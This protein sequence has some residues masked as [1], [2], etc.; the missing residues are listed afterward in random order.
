MT[1]QSIITKTKVKTFDIEFDASLADLIVYHEQFI[2]KDNQHLRLLSAQLNRENST[3]QKLV[4]VKFLHTSSIYQVH[5]HLTKFIMNL[6]L[7]ALLSIF[8]FV[9]SLVKKL[10]KNILPEENNIFGRSVSNQIQADLEEFRVIV[11]SKV[12][13]LF[14]VQVQGVKVDISD[15]PEKTLINLILSDLRVFDPY[16]GARYRKII[17]QQGN[18]KELLRIDITLFTYPDGYKKPL[19]AVDCDVKMQ[20]AKANIIFLFKHIDIILVNL[21]SN[22][23]H[24]DFDYFSEF[25]RFIRYHNDGTRYYLSSS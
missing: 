25:Y 13:Q 1:L 17:S 23:I 19:D 3:D 9:D 18:E 11:A 22:K 10:P 2:D 5:I 15:T 4:N 24:Q 12:T 20:F 14:D 21:V 7:E 8:K 16:E 6:Q